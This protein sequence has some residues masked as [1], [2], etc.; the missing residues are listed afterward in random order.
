[1]GA[2]A[3]SPIAA[4]PVRSP[5]FAFGYAVA[6]RL[7]GFAFGY[8]GQAGYPASPSATPWQAGYCLPPPVAA[9]LSST[10]WARAWIRRA[11]LSV[12]D[13]AVVPVIRRIAATTSSGF[14]S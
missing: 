5:G 8:A 4:S 1:M 14:V 2:Q 11:S 3:T 13:E 12:S 7:P 10:C 9:R 6:S